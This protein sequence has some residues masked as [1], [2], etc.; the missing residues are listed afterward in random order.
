MTTPAFEAF[1][2]KIYTDA[3]FRRRFL[4]DPQRLAAEHGLS[5]EESSHLMNI[6][7]VGLELA[8]KTFAYKRASAR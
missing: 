8:A 7:R 4:D 1:L 5:E 6:D 2:A 3:D